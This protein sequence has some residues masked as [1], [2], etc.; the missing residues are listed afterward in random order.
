MESKHLIVA[1]VLTG[2]VVVVLGLVVPLVT[3]KSKKDTKSP[4]GEKD[5]SGLVDD[6]P[7]RAPHEEAAVE[8][9]TEDLLVETEPVDTEP[10]TAETA[11]YSVMI[12]PAGAAIES[13]ELKN[14]RYVRDAG[15]DRTEPV[16]I[17]SLS[18]KGH[19]L[20]LLTLEGRSGGSPVPA[21]L[22]YTLS[23]KTDRNVVFK[24][25][26]KGWEIERAFTLKKDPY[27]IDVVT[28]ITNTTD[29]KRTIQ[30]LVSVQ[31][32][33]KSAKGTG[34]LSFLRPQ[35]NIVKGACMLDGD[36]ERRDI[37]KISK[38]GGIER[39][40]KVDFLSLDDLYFTSAIIPL[41]DRMTDAKP[42]GEGTE[43]VRCRVGP[44]GAGGLRGTLDFGKR[45]IAPGETLV[46]P[47]GS[48]L[49]PKEYE[50]LAAAGHGLGQAV[51]YGWFGGLARFLYVL[52]RTFDGWVHNWAIAII[53]LTVLV[54]LVL[55]PLTHWSF[56]SMQ[57]MQT[58][59][60]LI[61]DLNARFPEA[62]DRDKKNQALM[63]L[64]KTHKINPFMGC[65]PMLLQMPIWIALYRM[66]ANSVELYRTPLI[67]WIHDMSQPDPF[68]VLP[69]VLGGSMFLQQKITPTT[70]D[71]QQAKIML[72][73]MPIMFTVFMLFLPAGLNLYILVNTILTM[74]QQKI[75]YRPKVA[76]AAASQ[77]QLMSDMA[78]GELE[79]K[80]RA[81]RDRGADHGRGTKGRKKR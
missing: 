74:A 22:G 52:L 59:K 56:K 66:L 57:K 79:S 63:G 13:L 35:L 76:T 29:K 49:G 42:D 50:T 45:E 67:L 9:D 28:S 36:L 18:A 11:L 12:S 26:S 46:V 23:E 60:P 4:E 80:L 71:S 54:K 21:D 38:K 72:Y 1:V 8:D 43:E 6:E 16:D 78:P 3:G 30:P 37:A 41:W 15:K 73:T 47:V 25:R 24:A 10:T 14:P 48:Y 64:Y 20:P 69:I 31:K 61:D 33:L 34:I 51:D 44:D 53:M 39:M 27:E 19:P 68:F 75:L 17:V 77:V 2:L 40:G 65:V 70:A 32:Y 62:E 55:S 81:R 7:E 5:R 58:I